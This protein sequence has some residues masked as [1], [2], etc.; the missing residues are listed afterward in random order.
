MKISNYFELASIVLGSFDQNQELYVYQG[1]VMNERYIF[2]VDE[3]TLWLRHVQKVAHIDH[4]YIDGDTGGLIL[5]EHI[6][7]NAKEMLELI[8]DRLSGMDAL[9]FLTD[10]LLWTPDRV[11]MNLK[12]DRFQ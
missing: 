1:Y 8:V 5:A 4:F 11:D 6:T 7:G 2:F 10:V 12:L 9:T 3:G